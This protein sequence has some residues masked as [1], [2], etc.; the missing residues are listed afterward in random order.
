MNTFWNRPLVTI[1]SEHVL[2]PH[3]WFRYWLVTWNAASQYMHQSW[4]QYST[5]TDTQW[6]FGIARPIDMEGENICMRTTVVYYSSIDTSM[7]EM[8]FD[9]CHDAKFVLTGGLEVITMISSS[10]NSD[11]KVGIMQTID[12]CQYAKFVVAGGTEGYHN[13]IL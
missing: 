10:T 5:T 1:G 8:K 9:N 4:I 3:H 11:G 12:S 2:A 6:P 13:V 7:T